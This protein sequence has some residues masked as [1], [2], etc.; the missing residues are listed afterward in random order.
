M[1]PTG[2]ASI[3]GLDSIKSRPH[4]PFMAISKEEELLDWSGSNCWFC[5]RLPPV[6]GKSVQV[7]M[8][9]MKYGTDGSMGWLYTTVAVPRCSNCC[10]GH[11]RVI[12]R[13]MYGAFGGGL[14]TFVILALWA[15]GGMGT[16]FKVFLALV[17]A[18]IGGFLMA[19]F[20]DLPDGQKPSSAGVSFISVQLML[21]EDWI[22][23]DTPGPGPS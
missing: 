22:L 20:T 13:S 23:T 19:E 15:P 4:T 2:A 6:H 5:G 14:A 11:G 9:K 18:G 17:A 7:H 16:G 8:R 1:F 3:R 10:D 21:K 12:E